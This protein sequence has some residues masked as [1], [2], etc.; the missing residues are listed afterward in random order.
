MVLNRWI[1]T[2]LG[3]VTYQIPCISDIHIVT[4]NGSKITV[5]K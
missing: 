3:R 1:V 2:P 4:H 5:M